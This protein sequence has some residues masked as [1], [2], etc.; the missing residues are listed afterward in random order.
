MYTDDCTDEEFDPQYTPYYQLRIEYTERN[1]P[2]MRISLTGLVTEAV[3]DKLI[4]LTEHYVNSKNVRCRMKELMKMPDISNLKF[5][6]QD[7]VPNN[8]EPRV[9]TASKLAA[10]AAY[11]KGSFGFPI[12]PP[13]YF[14]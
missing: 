4:Y 1:R 8:N 2:I 9:T 10:N 11:G 5:E 12:L 3:P 14:E 6:L 13:R 7:V